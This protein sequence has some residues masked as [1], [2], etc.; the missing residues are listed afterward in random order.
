MNKEMVMVCKCGQ[1]VQNTKGSGCTIKQMDMENCTMQMV[2]SMKGN[3]TMTKRMD[4]ENTFM[5]MAPL[6]MG[7]GRKTDNMVLEWKL[8]QT[9]LNIKVFIM[10]GRNMA[11]ACLILLM[12]P[13]MMENFIS[14]KFQVKGFTNGAMENILKVLGSKTKC[15]GRE[16]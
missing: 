10:K 14:M 7:S 3:G 1:M 8:G 12:D 2:I 15:T 16:I 6:M 11:R 13:F 4:K 9:V 5:Q